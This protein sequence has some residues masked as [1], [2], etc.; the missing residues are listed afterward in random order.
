MSFLIYVNEVKWPLF[1][2]T[3]EEFVNR[4]LSIKKN[5][6][7]ENIENIEN[8]IFEYIDDQYI[9]SLFESWKTVDNIKTERIPLLREAIELYKK[10][11]YYGSTSLLMCQMDGLANDIFAANMP[12]DLDSE[13]IEKIY[14]VYAGA[15]IQNSHDFHSIKDVKKREKLQLLWASG[16]VEHGL[17]QWQIIIKYIYESIYASG[18]NADYNNPCRNKICHGDQLN[19]GTKK[20]AMKA[21]LVID[22]LFNL[23]YEHNCIEHID[24]VGFDT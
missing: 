5:H 3:D 22:L 14:R 1:M 16:S 10:G 15:Q 20:H 17:L 23:M 19:Y 24:E 12:N 8:A 7:E 21:I 9:D 4:I 11:Y 13:I 6:N 18:N 2:V